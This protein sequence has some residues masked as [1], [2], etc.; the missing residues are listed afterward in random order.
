[1][2]A[3]DQIRPAGF[4]ALNNLAART[5]A[6]FFFALAFISFGCGGPERDLSIVKIDSGTVSGT[7]DGDVR[8]F[9][10]IPYA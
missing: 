2:T 8:V 5:S 7:I 10:G 6:L 1:M 9:R 4:C 3:I